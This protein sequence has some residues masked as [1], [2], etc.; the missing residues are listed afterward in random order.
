MIEMTGLNASCRE[1][2][3]SYR[4]IPDDC[5]VYDSGRQMICVHRTFGYMLGCDG[6]ILNRGSPH[7]FVGQMPILNRS[8]ADMLRADAAFGYIAAADRAVC[9]YAA[10]HAAACELF[11]ND[12]FV[13]QMT[14]SYRPIRDMLLDNGA[15]GNVS[16]G[17]RPVSDMRAFHDVCR[18]MA[19]VNSPLLN[20]GR[21]NGIRRYLCFL[22]GTLCQMPGLHGFVCNFLGQNALIG[23][24]R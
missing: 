1:L 20:V 17:D 3:C 6:L 9:Q 7:A 2:F 4:F 13:L 5:V 22:D 10:R 21:L 11:T 24:F 18:N 8:R 14:G 23:N 15:A 19:A 12:R 16:R